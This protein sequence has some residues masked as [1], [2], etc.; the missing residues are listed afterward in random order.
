MES[1]APDNPA[2]FSA[3]QKEYLLGFF[4]GTT[5]R[6]IPPFV[7]HTPSGL[8]TDD[9]AAGLVNRAETAEETFHGTPVSDLSREELWKYEQNP[10]DIWDK[11]LAHADE[12]RAP[13]PK[14][15]F[16]SSFMGCSM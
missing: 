8:L 10:L 16:D 2:A 4:A 7:G 13:K 15:S 6:G 11:L 9:P 14:T 1:L 3:E 12:N 5:Q